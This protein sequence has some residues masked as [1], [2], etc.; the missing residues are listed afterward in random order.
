M[1]TS[2]NHRIWMNVMLRHRRVNVHLLSHTPKIDD[3]ESHLFAPIA[4]FLVGPAGEH[5][6]T[7]PSPSNFMSPVAGVAVDLVVVLRSLS[8]RCLV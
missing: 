3:R 8:A 5:R 1:H 6:D 4:F 7:K 2:T